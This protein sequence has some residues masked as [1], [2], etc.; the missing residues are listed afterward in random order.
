MLSGLSLSEI[1]QIAILAIPIY[2]GDLSNKD[3]YDF[4]RSAAEPAQVT[5]TES[6]AKNSTAQRFLGKLIRG[7]R[8]K[9]P[10]EFQ[11]P[12]NIFGAT[13]EESISRAS[14]TISTF[15]VENSHIIYGYI[16]IV[17]AKT[18]I[19]LKEIGTLNPASMLPRKLHSPLR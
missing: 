14:V 7:S 16:P 1:S 13:L 19:F 5:G 6:H 3:A 9:T 8:Q 4:E 10:P 2:P 12:G 15:G 17:I 11:Q 18:G